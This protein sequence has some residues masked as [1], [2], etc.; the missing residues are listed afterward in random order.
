MSE[1]IVNQALKTVIEHTII[2]EL[3]NKIKKLENEVKEYKNKTRRFEAYC[4]YVDINYNGHYHSEYKTCIMCDNICIHHDL[5]YHDC[6]RHDEY[7]EAFR[8][9][10]CQKFVCDRCYINIIDT[11]YTCSLDCL[12]ELRKK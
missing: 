2:K 9:C 1:L 12:N 10:N 11:P 4:E 5:C 3:E 6:D 7:P 8:C